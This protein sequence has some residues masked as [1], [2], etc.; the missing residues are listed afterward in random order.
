MCMCACR[1]TCKC[2]RVCMC[3]YVRVDKWQKYKTP[4]KSNCC[5]HSQTQSDL[6][7]LPIGNRSLQCAETRTTYA[8]S[9]HPQIADDIAARLNFYIEYQRNC[10]RCGSYQTDLTSSTPAHAITLCVLI[11]G[12]APALML[13]FSDP[14]SALFHRCARRMCLPPVQCTWCIYV[15][16][17]TYKSSDFED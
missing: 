1:C 11:L 2:V 16:F 6:Y 4:S 7:A 15:V 13:A 3:A 14:F 17:T 8:G 9:Q 12:N 5:K 10:Q